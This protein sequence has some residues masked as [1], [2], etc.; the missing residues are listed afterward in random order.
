VE[1]FNV[2]IKEELVFE[3]LTKDQ[4]FNEMEELARKA[5]F[6]GEPKADSIRIEQKNI[7]D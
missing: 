3:N 2:Y 7:E 1:V 5:Y 6:E 4:F